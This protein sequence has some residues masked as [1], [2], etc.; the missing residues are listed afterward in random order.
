MSTYI[1][2]DSYYGC[3]KIL[4]RIPDEYLNVNKR[5]N[6]KY[7]EWKEKQK[8]LFTK[9]IKK[10]LEDKWWNNLSNKV[11]QNFIQKYIN[12][13]ENKDKSNI[14][15]FIK[16]RSWRFMGNTFDCNK[17]ITIKNVNDI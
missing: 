17:Y 15:N 8:E 12:V 10:N 6:K 11:Q 9:K 7:K 5:K 1:K 2:S 13:I 3:Y 16:N 14:I 4:K